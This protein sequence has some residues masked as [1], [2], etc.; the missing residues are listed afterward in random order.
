VGLTCRF[1]NGV[2][3]APIRGYCVVQLDS[4]RGCVVDYRPETVEENG[5]G[6]RVN[7]RA[8]RPDRCNV[9]EVSSIAGLDVSGDGT[10]C[11]KGGDVA[12]A[13][14]RDRGERTEVSR[15]VEVD[16]RKHLG[17]GGCAALWGV[18]GDGD[19]EGMQEVLVEEGQPVCILRTELYGGCKVLLGDRG[20][21]GGDNLLVGATLPD[22][23]VVD[24]AGDGG[25]EHTR[26]GTK[27]EV[28]GDEVVLGRR[29]SHTHWD[30]STEGSASTIT[31][32]GFTAGTVVCGFATLS[33]DSRTIWHREDF[34]FKMTD[35]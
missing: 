14:T 25:P 4:S 29:A 13:V 3:K 24:V 17:T 33:S 19:N 9:G 1:S 20:R 31:C 6:A 35:C 34:I 11:S 16:R 23:L 30:Q 22:D 28:V 15:R 10:A 12:S 21:G 32:A 27:A 2:T 18:V 26:G 8:S 7:P 5:R